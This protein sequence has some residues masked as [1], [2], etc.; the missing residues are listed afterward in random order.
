[1]VF[2][3]INDSNILLGNIQML[4][5]MYFII[6]FIY[7]TLLR[8]LMYACIFPFYSVLSCIGGGL[9]VS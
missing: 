4:L 3:K 6:L 5:K 8:A 2:V 7:L 9:A 1:M